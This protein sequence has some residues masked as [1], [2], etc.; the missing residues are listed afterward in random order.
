MIPPPS[1]LAFSFPTTQSTKL[2]LSLYVAHTPERF[3]LAPKVAQLLDL[4][5]SDRVGVVQA[6]WSYVKSHGLQDEEKKCVRTDARLKE[7]GPAEIPLASEGE[8]LTC[9]WTRSSFRSRSVYPS[10]TCRNTS[11][12]SWRPPPLRS[13]CT[14]CCESRSAWKG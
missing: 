3:S 14:M 13:S 8:K 5:E 7:V 11:T 4:H 6:L 1:G 2:R 10:I 9:P 12:A